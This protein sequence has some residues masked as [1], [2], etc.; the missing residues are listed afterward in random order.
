MLP[1]FLGSLTSTLSSVGVLLNSL[2]GVNPDGS[3]NTGTTVTLGGTATALSEVAIFEDGVVIGVAAAGLNGSWSFT[4]S[5]LT[6][7]RHRITLEAVNADGVLG[8]MVDTLILDA[9]GPAPARARRQGRLRS[10]PRRQGRG[11]PQ[12]GPV[13]IAGTRRILAVCSR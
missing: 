4:A 11:T 7:G 10:L 1:S 5:G 13:L 2:L 6:T 9:A 3:I 12:S 8:S